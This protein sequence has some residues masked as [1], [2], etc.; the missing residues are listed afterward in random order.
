[1]N[2]NVA[3][4]RRATRFSALGHTP[5]PVAPVTRPAALEFPL[6]LDLRRG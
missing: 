1:V 2:A 5:A 6:T 4:A 3:E